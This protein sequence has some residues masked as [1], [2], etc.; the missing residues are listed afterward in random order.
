MLGK[1]ERRDAG[2]YAQR[3]PL[4]AALH[5][6]AHL[7]QFTLYQLW[8]AACEFGQLHALVHLGV[9]LIHG[10]AILCMDERGQFFAVL[11]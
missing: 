4:D 11:R 7:Q 5:A 8:Q 1:V 10:L 6:L 2:H 3:F 9:R